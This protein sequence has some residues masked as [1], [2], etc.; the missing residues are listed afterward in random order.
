[1]TPLGIDDNIPAF[2]WQMKAP[3]DQYGVSQSAYQI[4][5]KDS[6]E[7]VV[8]DSQKITSGLSLNISDGGASLQPSTNY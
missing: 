5:G 2:A 1:M 7:T 4:I 6:K 3:N 8:W